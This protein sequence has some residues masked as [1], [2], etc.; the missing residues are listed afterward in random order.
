MLL[1]P[2]YFDLNKYFIRTE[3]MEILNKKVGVMNNHTDIKLVIFGNTC[4]IGKDD[5]N[6]VLGEKRAESARK[7]L[8]SKGIA[9]E[10]MIIRTLSRFEPEL[11]NTDE[12]NRS[13]NRRDDFRP[14]FPKKRMM[15]W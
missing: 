12:F 9:Q 1:E 14:L 15:M 13:H 4:D 6:Y 5:Y 8:M 7:Y 3:S 10:R 11:P 2:I